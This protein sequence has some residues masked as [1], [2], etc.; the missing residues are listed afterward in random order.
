MPHSKAKLKSQTHDDIP[1]DV[2]IDD[3]R[4]VS[5]Y[6]K[7]HPALA[8]LI[9]PIC[10]RLRTEFGE[11]AALQ[12]VVYRD[13]EFYD[14]HLVIYVR[15]PSYDATVLERIRGVTAEFDDALTDASGWL[16]VATDFQRI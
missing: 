6:L 5:R 1:E 3:R 13:P 10:A 14:P 4:A 9:P 11:V 7:P 8:S 16:L 2:V 12:L 15:L